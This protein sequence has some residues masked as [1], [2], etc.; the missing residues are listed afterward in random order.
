MFKVSQETKVFDTDS[1]LTIVTGKSWKAVQEFVRIK[2]WL[3]LIFL[4]C[5]DDQLN[6]THPIVT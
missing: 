1:F 5:L 2:S 4:I 6:S 3:L